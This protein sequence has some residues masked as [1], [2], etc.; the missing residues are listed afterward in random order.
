[1]LN[2]MMGVGVRV[3][4]VNEERVIP[5]LPCFGLCGGFEDDFVLGVKVGE[6][7]VVRT[8]TECGRWR[9][10]C[11]RVVDSGGSGVEVG[12]EGEVGGEEV[13]E[14]DLLVLWKEEETLGFISSLS[15]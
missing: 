4:V 2:V 12:C 14:W 3:R 9:I 11:R 8:T 5:F 10:R 13:V 7:D 6:V 1:M 15:C